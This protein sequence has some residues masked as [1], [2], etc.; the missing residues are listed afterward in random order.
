MLNAYVY[1]AL[2]AAAGPV[3][4]LPHMIVP[5]VESVAFVRALCKNWRGRMWCDPGLMLSASS[6]L[7]LLIWHRCARIGLLER[8]GVSWVLLAVAQTLVDQYV[9]SIL[10]SLGVLPV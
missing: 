5:F 6:C 8:A 2:I 4:L 9:G 10:S 1:H 7:W 3:D